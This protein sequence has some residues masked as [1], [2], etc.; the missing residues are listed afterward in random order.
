VGIVASFYGF[1]QMCDGFFLVRDALLGMF[2]RFL[3]MPV[4]SRERG[5]RETSPE[6]TTDSDCDDDSFNV[7]HNSSFVVVGS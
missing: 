7:V 6:K 5:D 4:S 1:F 3:N 2:D